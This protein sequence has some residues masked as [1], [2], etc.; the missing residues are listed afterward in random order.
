MKKLCWIDIET[1]GLDPNTDMI[2]EICACIT[3]ERGN[4][5]ESIPFYMATGGLCE[6]AE[7]LL[8]KNAFVT[9]MH[10]QSGLLWDMEQRGDQPLD[11]AEFWAWAEEHARG[12]HLA[13]FSVH[14]D[15]SFLMPRA[16]EI[17]HHR[18]VDM[19][20]IE[21]ALLAAGFKSPRGEK[22]PAH[23]APADVRAAQHA[24]WKA[25]WALEGRVS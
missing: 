7:E 10:R 17:F 9:N 2:L 11:L 23:R 22:R 5:D 12:T 8:A 20:S 1:T 14:F 24:Y 16:G 3:D 21:I 6:R 4:D 18:I 13:G 25:L 19:S 15:R